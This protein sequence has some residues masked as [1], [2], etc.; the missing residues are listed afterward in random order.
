MDNKRFATS[1]HI[2]ALLTKANE[3]RLCSDFI[4]GSINI[5]PVTVRKELSNLSKFGFITTKEGKGG[6][7]ALAKAA[8][9][10]NLAD[11]YLSVRSK[12]ILGNKPNDPNQ[13]CP[14]GRQINRELE[15]IFLLAEDAL[16]E[17]LRTKT[18]AEFAKQF[19]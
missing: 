13:Q 3:E 9:N 18:L 17:Q 12:N 4:A 10:I 1:I 14:V 11:V 16:L 2:L 7:T 6:G 19:V 15:K 5:N 8:E